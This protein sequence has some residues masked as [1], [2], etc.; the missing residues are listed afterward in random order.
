MTSL[1][2]M[3]RGDQIFG[4]YGNPPNSKLFSDYGFVLSRQENV[5]EVHIE[6]DKEDP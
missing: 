1:Q 2:N 5:Y 3:S 6:L 4:V